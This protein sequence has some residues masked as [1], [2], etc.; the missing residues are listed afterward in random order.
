MM[1]KEYQEEGGEMGGGWM[2][3]CSEHTHHWPKKMKKDFKMAL[4]R[5]KEKMLEA[6]LAFVR[7]MKDLFEKM[8][9]EEM[10]EKEDAEEKE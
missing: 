2:S 3:C 5:K 4:L 6:K 1:N 9:P 7:E 8:P 10:K